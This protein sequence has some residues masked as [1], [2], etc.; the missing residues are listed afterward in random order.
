MSDTL[1]SQQPQPVTVLTAAGRAR[2]EHRLAT[3]RTELEQLD[4]AATRSDAVEARELRASLQGRVDSLRSILASAV[5]PSEI[6][7]DPSI[8]EVGDE[9]ELAFPDGERERF[10]LVHPIEIAADTGHVSIESP[11]GRALLGRKIG[12]TVA[13]RAPGGAYEVEIIARQRSR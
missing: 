6:S 4:A 9:V 12:E 1:A 13:V 7:D 8:I 11:L 3:A 2:L 5:S 10:V